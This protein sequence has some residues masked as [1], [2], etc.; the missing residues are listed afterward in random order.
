MWTCTQEVKTISP[1]GHRKIWEQ[2][3]VEGVGEGFVVDFFVVAVTSFRA[4]L[5][6]GLLEGDAGLF[7]A[8]FVL[9]RVNSPL[10]QLAGQRFDNVAFF[11]G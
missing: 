5:A 2:G 9:G 4:Q 10:L 1:Y 8:A 7:R 6:L 11:V 3:V